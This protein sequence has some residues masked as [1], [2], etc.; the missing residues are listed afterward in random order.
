MNCDIIPAKYRLKIGCTLY[1]QKYQKNKFHVGVNFVIY[2]YFKYRDMFVSVM[3]VYW[4][5]LP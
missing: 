4:F 3:R 5:H 2:I 1:H